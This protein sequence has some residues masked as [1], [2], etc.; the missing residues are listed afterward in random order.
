MDA[1]SRDDREANGF[2]WG[3]IVEVAKLFAGIFITHHPGARDAAR[4]ADGALRRWWRSVTDPDGCGE[5]RRL[6]LADRRCCRP[7]ST[8]R[9]PISS[10]SSSRAAMRRS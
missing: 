3:P 6:F 4:R 7:S 8:M 1:D 5:Q 10:S 2:T 9:R